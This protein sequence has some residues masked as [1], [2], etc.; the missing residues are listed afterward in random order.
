[1]P[2]AQPRALDVLFFKITSSNVDLPS[3]TLKEEII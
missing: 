2:M 1:M 3:H